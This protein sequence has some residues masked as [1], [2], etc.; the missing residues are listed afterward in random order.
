MSFY[1]YQAMDSN[2][3]NQE[4]NTNNNISS[5]CVF[6]LII[7]YIEF[8]EHGIFSM[9]ILNTLF[10]FIQRKYDN[11]KLFTCFIT[12][13]YII[14]YFPSQTSIKMENNKLD[15][16]YSYEIKKMV[17]ENFIFVEDDTNV[18]KKLICV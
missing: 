3:S 14:N 10:E 16:H 17:D 15:N 6:E 2:S 4:T 7:A 9:L 1:Q 13:Y 12:S 5:K 8:I 18:K 11:N